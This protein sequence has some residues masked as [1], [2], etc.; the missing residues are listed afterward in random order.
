MRKKAILP[1]VGVGLLALGGVGLSDVAS[2]APGDPVVVTSVEPPDVNE[3]GVVETA[4]LPEPAEPAE[5]PEEA[6]DPEDTG[7]VDPTD[8]EDPVDST[9]AP[10]PAAVDGPEEDDEETSG[11]VALNDGAAGA[12]FGDVSPVPGNAQVLSNA[13]PVGGASTGAGGTAGTDERDSAPFAAAGGLG[14]VLLAAAAAG[15]RKRGLIRP[16]TPGER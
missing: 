1:I 6:P 7:V 13:T 14:A 11:A 8:V 15:M 12:A 16:T 2:A 10:G 5:Q 9:D 3:G 4:D